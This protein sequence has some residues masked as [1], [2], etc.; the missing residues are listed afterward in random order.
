MVEDMVLLL[1]LLVVAQVTAD[2]P[3]LSNPDISKIIGEKWKNEGDEVKQNWKKLAEEE[4]QRHQNQYPNYRYQPRRGNKPQPGWAS[5]SPTE[6]H[7]RCPKCHGR[8]MAT[9]QTPSTPFAT[10]PAG[11]MAA[12]A[13]AASQGPP[14]L[15]RLDTALSRRSSF[16][17][18]PT[19]GLPFPSAKLP[20]VR[21]VEKSE[22]MSPE[23][24]RRRADGAGAYHVINGPPLGSYAAAKP[25]GADLCLT[26]T[27]GLAAN[28]LHAVARCLRP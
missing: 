1:L 21:D 12:A 2:N 18:S 10:S 4:K 26:P 3:K 22:P 6:E 27:D 23:M 5:T 24:K 7:G 19:S 17:Q 8:A 13:A 16:E 28:P 25:P 15:Q 11:K 20:P 14:S 9:P